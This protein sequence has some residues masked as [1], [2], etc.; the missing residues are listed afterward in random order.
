[1][2]NLDYQYQIFISLEDDFYDQDGNCI[3]PIFQLA[4]D[5]RTDLGDTWYIGTKYM[6]RYFTVYNNTQTLDNQ[7]LGYNY[8][9]IARC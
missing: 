7:P 5:D 9:G 8:F 2:L 4:K 6:E 3:I 1:M